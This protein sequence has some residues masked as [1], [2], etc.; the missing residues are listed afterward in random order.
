[1]N[2]KWILSGKDGGMVSLTDAFCPAWHNQGLFLLVL[3]LEFCTPIFCGYW[4]WDFAAP[5]VEYEGR[6]SY[7]KIRQLRLSRRPSVQL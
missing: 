7:L 5:A 2:G 1:M 4:L 3:S 6:S